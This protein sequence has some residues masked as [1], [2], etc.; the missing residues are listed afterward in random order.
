MYI[1]FIFQYGWGNLSP[2]L[3]N[4]YLSPQTG[5]EKFSQVPSLNI[6]YHYAILFNDSYTSIWNWN[7]N[8]Y[9]STT[10]IY[11]LDLIDLW[12]W[13][14]D[15]WLHSWPDAPIHETLTSWRGRDSQ[16]LNAINLC[17]FSISFINPGRGVGVRYVF[18]H[19]YM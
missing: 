13:H 17:M 4:K 15:G 6:L 3:C 19:I 7:T 14:V 16:I 12:P 2:H 5:I 1:K 8:K 9:T 11:D 18:L 10:H